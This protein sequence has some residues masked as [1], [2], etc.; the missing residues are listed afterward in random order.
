MNEIFL[1]YKCEDEARVAPIVLGLRSAR[2]SVWW[3][4]DISGGQAWR[5]SISEHLET[6][7]CV[8]VVWSERSVGPLAEFV[9]DEAKRGQARGVLLPV[10]I[11]PVTEP[12]GFGEIQTLDLVGWR[13]NLRDPR[14]QDLVAAVKAVVSGGPRPRPKAPGRRARLLTA[15]GSGLGV[16]VILLVAMNLAALQ[17]PLCKVPGLHAVCA[18]WG[19]GGVPTKAEAALWARRA[20]GD[21][22]SLKAYLASFPKGAFAEEAARRLQAAATVEEE[23]WTPQTQSLPLTVRATLDP[24]PSEQA[25]RA[26]ALARGA[27]EA[28]RT[29]EGFKAG[30]FRLVAATA[31]AQSWRCSARG[32]GAVCG[33]DGQAICRVEARHVTER[34]VC[35]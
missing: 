13:G 9:H 30:E 17:K 18:A 3:D 5:Q 25:A 16:T 2:L 28:R 31:E 22:A 20:P 12:L 10:R 4:R 7:R 34:Q 1:S 19:L 14:F 32:A 6:S 11:D 29:C 8:I 35:R 21:C 27:T 23:H 15:W 33:F 26:D 24:L